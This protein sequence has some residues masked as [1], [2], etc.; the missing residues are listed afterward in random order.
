MFLVIEGEARIDHPTP[1]QIFDALASLDGAKKTFMILELPPGSYIQVGGGSD[2]YTAEVRV[3]KSA[4]EYKHWKAEIPDTKALKKRRIYIAGS[5]VSVMHNQVL[6][7][8]TV[9]KLIESF[10]N[11]D[12]LCACVKWSDMTSMFI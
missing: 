4:D 5:Q 9:Q 7:Q 11:G 8:N 10:V 2:E 6:N 1:E 12:L 3:Y